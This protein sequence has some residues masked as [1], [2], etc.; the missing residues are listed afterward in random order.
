VARAVIF[1]PKLISHKSLTPRRTRSPVPISSD[2]ASPA[3]AAVVV[4]VAVTADTTSSP[5]LRMRSAAVRRVRQYRCVVPPSDD[6]LLDVDASPVPPVLGGG[7]RAPPLLLPLLGTSRA[8]SGREHTVLI[9]IIIVLYLHR[10]H[11]LCI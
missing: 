4:V 2:T 6:V 9:C 7:V 3:A 8:A 5:L 11:E 1:L 10:T